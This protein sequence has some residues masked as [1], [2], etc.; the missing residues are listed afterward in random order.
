MHV[1]SA[2]TE[3]EILWHLWRAVLYCRLPF[4]NC[5]LLLFCFSARGLHHL[6]LYGGGEVV[7]GYITEGENALRSAAW[8]DFCQ[9]CFSMKLKRIKFGYTLRQ[10]LGIEG[11]KILP[12]FKT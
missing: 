3:N 2:E 6:F 5:P 9:F 12:S 7:V 11:R 8:P 1:F 10:R 4:S